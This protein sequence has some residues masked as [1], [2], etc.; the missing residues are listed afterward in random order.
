MMIMTVTRV[1]D[2]E[3]TVTDCQGMIKGAQKHCD[4]RIP[5]L[6]CASRRG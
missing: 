1:P 4:F 3:M 5:K 6:R 2:D